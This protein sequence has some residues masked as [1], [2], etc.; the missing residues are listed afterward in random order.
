[1]HGITLFFVLLYRYRR[2]GAVSSNKIG[3]LVFD[4]AKFILKMRSKEKVH[5][6]F[7]SFHL[8]A[9]EMGQRIAAIISEIHH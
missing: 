6:V 3:R 7:F 8:C 9:Q 5:V 2:N 4:L 1:M